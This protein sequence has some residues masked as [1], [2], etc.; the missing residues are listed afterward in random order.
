MIKDAQV[1]SK[2]A[3]LSRWLPSK[4]L[5]NEYMFFMLAGL[6]FAR[7]DFMG[8]INTF[9]YA[10]LIALFLTG[11]ST[12]WGALG[13]IAGRLTMLNTAAVDAIAT[14]S[15]VCVYIG[16]WALLAAM[17]KIFKGDSKKVYIISGIV[18]YA[19]AQ[20]ALMLLYQFTVYKLL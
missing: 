20:I 1:Y 3:S 6:L 7:V 14:F 8:V 13:V 11:R 4:A 9:G 17:K 10:W 5:L 15:D 12:F 19:A 18:F 2:G 16:V